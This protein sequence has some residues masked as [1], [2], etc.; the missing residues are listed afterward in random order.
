MPKPQAIALLNPRKV[1]C[2]LNQDLTHAMVIKSRP[3]L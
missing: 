3:S 1:G 2:L